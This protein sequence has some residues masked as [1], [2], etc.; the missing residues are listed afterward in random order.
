MVPSATWPGGNPV[1]AVPGL[2][3][4]SP[5][6]IDGPV[7]VTVLPA[8]TPKGAAVPRPTAGWAAYAGPEA[9]NVMASARRIARTEVVDEARRAREAGK[10]RPSGIGVEQDPQQ[11]L[12]WVLDVEDGTQMTECHQPGTKSNAD[13]IWFFTRSQRLPP[14][15]TRT[16]RQRSIRRAAAML[17]VG[18][19]PQ[20]TAKVPLL[21]FVESQRRQSAAR[22]NSRMAR[23]TRTIVLTAQP[24]AN[25]PVVRSRPGRNG[26]SRGFSIIRSRRALLVL[27]PRQSRRASR[28]GRRVARL[29]RCFRFTWSCDRTSPG[30]SKVRNSWAVGGGEPTAA[31]SARRLTVNHAAGSTPIT[32]TTTA[33]GTSVAVPVKEQPIKRAAPTTGPAE[34]SSKGPRKR[35]TTPVN[36]RMMSA[37]SLAAWSSHLAGAASTAVTAGGFPSATCVPAARAAVPE[38]PDFDRRN[39]LT[40]GSNAPVTLVKPPA[41]SSLPIAPPRP[42]DLPVNFAMRSAGLMPNLARSP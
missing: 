16:G 37:N 10:S 22:S 42:P 25:N 40:G 31:R 38:W 39:P 9:S 34:S 6:T 19:G 27:M 8:S 12:A 30:D 24:T 4:T 33:H 17:Q 1:I 21:R 35:R 7:L 20:P 14:R 28:V 3:P 5:C 36:S 29:G 23:P 18:C 13:A 2:T 15:S 32:A 11:K 41:H 26:D